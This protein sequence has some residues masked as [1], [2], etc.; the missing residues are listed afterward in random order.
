MAISII[1]NLTSREMLRRN[2][3]DLPHETER[4]FVDLP[5]GMY[6]VGEQPFR[7]KCCRRWRPIYKDCVTRSNQ[8]ALYLLECIDRGHLKGVA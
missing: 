3:Y 1:K 2:L 4:D 7:G 5:V 8:S 6:D